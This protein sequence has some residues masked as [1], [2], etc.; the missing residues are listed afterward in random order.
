MLANIGYV[1]LLKTR[2]SEVEAF[3]FLSGDA[4]DRSFPV[5]SLRPWPNANNLQLAVDRTTEAV[6]G[7][8]FALGLGSGPIKGIPKG[9][10]I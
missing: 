6:D 8:P 3:G 5:F 10:I 7:R 2:V 4:K 9:P 1:P